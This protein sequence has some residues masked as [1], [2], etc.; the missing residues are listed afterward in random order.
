VC[1]QDYFLEAP[2]VKNAKGSA[3]RQ[4][5]H[6]LLLDVFIFE[7]SHDTLGECGDVFFADVRHSCLLVSVQ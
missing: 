6:A 1:F 4:P 7:E 3:G 2:N 5:M